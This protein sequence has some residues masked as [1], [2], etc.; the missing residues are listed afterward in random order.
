MVTIATS[1]PT[2]ILTLPV[3]QSVCIV[4]HGHFYQPPR[5][6]PYLNV[7]EQQE[8]AAPFHDWNERIL[9]ECYRPNA[10]ARVETHDSQIL[11]VVNNYEYLS[12]NIGPTLL[13]WLEVADP[14]VYH[15][16]LLADQRSA[17][18]LGGHGNA[19]AQVYNHLIMPLA[20]QR[21]KLTQIRWGKADFRQRFGRE[22]EGMWLAETAVDRETLE[23][24]IEEELRFIVLAPSQAQRCRPMGE[25]GQPPAPWLEVGGSQ[26]NPTR[27]YRCFVGDDRDTYIDVFFYDG[28]IS[29]DMGFGPLLHSSSNFAHRLGQAVR[30]DCPQPQIISV[31][32]DGE[33][34]GHHKHFTEKTLAYAFTVEFPQRD[35]L[36]TNYAHYLSL[37]PPTWEVV[38]KPVTAWSCAHGVDRW[39]DDCGCGVEVGKGK[40]RRPL[41][42]T[43]NWLR[44]R[45]IPIYVEAASAYFE[46]VWG[47]RDGYIELLR[48]SLRHGMPQD[49]ALLESF[50]LTH[51]DRALG[52]AEQVRALQLLEM[53]RHSL[54]M[55]TSCG[56]F[57]EELSRPEGVQILRYASRAMELAAEVSGIFLEPEFIER[58]SQ[59][60]SEVF[61]DGAMV[62]RQMVVTNR[63]SLRQIAAN[64]AIASLFTTYRRS[65]PFFCYTIQQQDYHL[66]R[67]G[68][69]SLAIGQIQITSSITLESV[70]LVF[71]VLH[72]SG[73]DFHCHISSFDSRREYEQS[74]Q[75]LI[76]TFSQAS[77]ARVVLAMVEFFGG[78]RF[79]LHHLFVEER[80]RILHLL[81]SETLNR[82]DQLYAQ[83]YLDNYSL[84]ASFRREGLPVPTELQ[85]AAQ[86]TLEQRLHQELRRLEQGEQ[87]PLAEV[88]AVVSESRY[89]G[90]PLR[91]QATSHALTQY[92]MVQVRH[93]AHDAA[94]TTT[95]RQ[96]EET[97]NLAE[98]LNLDL[99]FQP[100]QEQFL[101][102]LQGRSPPIVAMLFP[103]WKNFLA[104]VSP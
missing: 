67:L 53:Q 32:T 95:L 97:L 13:S 99:N 61:G 21:D 3:A 87:L 36:V 62:Y 49:P 1:E 81:A 96:I 76:Q 9:F 22:P 45:L 75:Q 51:G 14:E 17:Q 38:L 70:T 41:R 25:Q 33:T 103:T 56:W 10:F 18:R 28:P 79:N 60:P 98:A 85:V 5:E 26:I 69:L 58:L 37:Y 35:W 6:N 29:R 88:Q 89:L 30:G 20:N 78:D 65:Q 44:D 19:I 42:E 77:A 8:S 73:D 91:S 15:Q 23:V 83:V 71:A 40:W 68:N 84:L 7:I 63:I 27:P 34:F 104:L 47:A 31:A 2:E 59:A 11:K 24:L 48:E 92:L 54:L 52:T 39:Q 57:F 4:I 64:Y 55:F 74:K 66:E 101:A 50:F 86:I 46:D 100:A 12:F 72:L 82:L 43:L 102:F 16:I 90:C 80:H 93:L 94:L